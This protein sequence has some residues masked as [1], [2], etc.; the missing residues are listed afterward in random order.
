MTDAT[1][2]TDPLR[3]AADTMRAVRDRCVWTQR[4]DHRALVR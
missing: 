2:L 1:P 4:I 3:E